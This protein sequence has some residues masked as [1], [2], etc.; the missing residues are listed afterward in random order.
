MR[1]YVIPF[2]TADM[3]KKYADVVI[4]GCGIAGLYTALMLPSHMDVMIVSKGSYKE[5]NSYLAQ[6]GVSSSFGEGTNQEFFNDTM[7]CGKEESDTR[8]VWTMI[9]GAKENIMELERLGVSF[10]KNHKGQF[11]FAKE[12]AHSTPRIIRSGDYTGK[13]IMEVL[14]S[15]VQEQ[16][17]IRL[18]ENRFAVDIL[19][20]NHKSVGLLIMEENIPS[21]IFSKYI[22]VNAGGIGHLY[23]HTTNAKGIQG[24]G[25]AM[26]LRANG[27]VSNM[28]Y[29][30]FHPTVFYDQR[31]NQKQSFLISEAV[32]GEG[33]A[34]LYNEKR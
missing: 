32:R 26:V 20:H 1:N 15:R 22:V 18:L 28:S 25:I 34:L 13:S 24:D 19:T 2:D 5:T 29:I 23:P 17:N 14:Y 8:A 12:G 21:V 4:I 6:G 3:Q 10:D 27:C 7:L 33:G 31:G 16:E 11:L 9:N 30:Q